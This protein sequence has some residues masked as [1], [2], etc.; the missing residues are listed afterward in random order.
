MKNQIIAVIMIPSISFIFFLTPSQSSTGTYCIHTCG[1][2]RT[3]IAFPCSPQHAYHHRGR[4]HQ[5]AF[6]LD[7]CF[8]LFYD[9]N[10]CRLVFFHQSVVPILPSLSVL[11]PLFSRIVPIHIY[12]KRFMVFYI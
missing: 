9:S 1:S 10:I 8:F 2:V 4:K 7:S 3:P 12:Y 6:L 11:V 5:F